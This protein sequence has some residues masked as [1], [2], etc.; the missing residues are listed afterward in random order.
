MADAAEPVTAAEPTPEAAEADE[1]LWKPKKP[2]TEADVD[3]IANPGYHYWHGTVP[4]GEGA[5]P[6]PVP[7]Q[8]ATTSEATLQMVNIDNF[9]FL[10]EDDV[11]DSPAVAPPA[12]A[13][14]P[15]R[16]TSRAAQVI[17]VYIELKGDLEGATEIVADFERPHYAEYFPLEVAACSVRRWLFFLCRRLTAAAPLAVRAQVAIR[18][19]KQMHVLKAEKLAGSLDSEAWCVRCPVAVLPPCGP[20]A[21]PPSL[22]ITR[23]LSSRLAA[24]PR[25]RAHPRAAQQ[26]QGVEEGRQGDRHAQEAAQ[27]KLG[28]AAHERVPAVPPRRRRHLDAAALVLSH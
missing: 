28:P 27:D 10:E 15:L 23:A 17:K 21:L 6:A 7:Q 9:M 20:C 13:P 11:C 25:P 4:K 26:G 18:G 5:A 1:P 3:A 2:E 24:P 22:G 19:K 16:R 12:A 8:I 14:D